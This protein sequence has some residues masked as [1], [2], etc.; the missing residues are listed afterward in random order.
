M[1]AE[2]TTPRAHDRPAHGRGGA[3]HDTA[4]PKR[5]PFTAIRDAALAAAPGEIVEVELDAKDSGDVYEF[6]ILSPRGRVIEVELDAA[7]GAVLK[8]E[9]E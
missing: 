4:S 9:R 5:L 7:S 2:Q 8:L 6:T 3:L 1:L